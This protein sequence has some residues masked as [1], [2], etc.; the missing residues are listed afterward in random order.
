MCHAPDVRFH[1]YLRS[2]S[3]QVSP[4]PNREIDSREMSSFPQGLLET[5]CLCPPPPKFTC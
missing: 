5:E 4:F 3:Q 1:V 2:L